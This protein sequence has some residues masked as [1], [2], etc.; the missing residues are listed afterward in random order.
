MSKFSHVRFEPSGFTKN[1]DV[2]MAK[3]L[4]DYIFRF[5]GARFL[6]GEQRAAVGLAERD[7]PVRGARAGTPTLE[8]GETTTVAARVGSPVPAGHPIGFA[9]GSAVAQA[10]IT[11]SPQADA[12]SCPECGSL[13]VRNGACYKCF[14]CGATSGCS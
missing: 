14:N 8:A 7:E 4:I 3:S 12:P 2:P 6:S 11:F 5:L 1:P 13:M 9:T 10:P